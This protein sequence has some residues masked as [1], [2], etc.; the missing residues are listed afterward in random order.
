M[1]DLQNNLRLNRLK[2]VRC[3]SEAVGETSGTAQFYHLPEGIPSSSS[4]S[5]EFMQGFGALKH[6]SVQVI[7]LDDFVA[8]QNVARLDLI[9]IDTESTEPAALRGLK[10]TL[11]RDKPDIICEVL[12][13][14]DTSGP[15]QEL[16]APIGYRFFLLS[17]NGPQLQENIVPSENQNWMNYWF[18]IRDDADIARL[19]KPAR[20]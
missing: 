17:E 14:T 5:Q 18:T 20:R 6:T 19:N 8:E 11:Q 1:R 15:L 13:G 4:L 9:K 3:Q 2:N 7:R 10:S 16:L 12:A